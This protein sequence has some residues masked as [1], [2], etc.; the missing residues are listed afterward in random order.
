MQVVRL[1]NN[2]NKHLANRFLHPDLVSKVFFKDA[3]C[4]S[5]LKLKSHGFPFPCCSLELRESSLM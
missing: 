2:K 4:G 3:R 5:H 1:D